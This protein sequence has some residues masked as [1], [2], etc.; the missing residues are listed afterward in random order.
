MSTR[1]WVYRD[2]GKGGVDVIE[3]GA[4]YSEAPRS[5]GD[6]GKFDYDNLR[7]PDGADISSRTKHR[8]Y[9]KAHNLT[10][11]DDF[12][13][14]WKQAAA[15]REQRK[16][17]NFDKAERKEAIARAIYNQRDKKR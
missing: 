13:G 1:R 10:V 15:E 11:A 6:L 3:V 4:D 2:N 14:E 17:G 5:T 9:M 12:K 8:E 16:Q 7:A